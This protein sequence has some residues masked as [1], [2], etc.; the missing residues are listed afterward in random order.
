VTE[1]C[2][3]NVLGSHDLFLPQLFLVTNLKNLSKT[4]VRNVVVK[5]KEYKMGKGKVVL[6]GP[7]LK[8]FTVVLFNPPPQDFSCRLSWS[9]PRPALAEIAKM[10]TIPPFFSLCF[11]Y[12][13]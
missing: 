5:E 6:F 12:S 8:L 9:S 2:V 11:F 10:A 13:L 4:R 1:S 7:T 3:S